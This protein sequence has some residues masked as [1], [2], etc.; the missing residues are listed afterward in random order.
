MVV[1]LT[2]FLAFKVQA[3]ELLTAL[4]AKRAQIKAIEVALIE[5]I[6][7]TQPNQPVLVCKQAVVR[8][9]DRSR[10]LPLNESDLREKLKAYLVEQ[11]GTG[12]SDHEKIE[13]FS[14]TI[15]TRIWADRRTKKETQ[16]TYKLHFV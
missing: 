5:E 7:T 12:V 4:K 8:V 1:D 13:E 10:R 6:K 11:F 2:E 3:E 14:D 16:L 15:V 9:F